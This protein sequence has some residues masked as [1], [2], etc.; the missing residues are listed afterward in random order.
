MA[1][2][3]GEDWLQKKRKILVASQRRIF[4]SQ[5]NNLLI[6]RYVLVRVLTP[7]K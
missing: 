7:I 1:S 5:E 4:L 2:K 6:K 3:N